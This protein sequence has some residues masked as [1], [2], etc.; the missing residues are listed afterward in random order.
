M[1]IGNITDGQY[2]EY[3]NLESHINLA[4]FPRREGDSRVMVNAYDVDDKKS[5]KGDSDV[6]F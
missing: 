4:A 1:K 3:I 5:F 2:G 6:P